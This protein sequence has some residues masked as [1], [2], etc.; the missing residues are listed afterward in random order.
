LKTPPDK[1][2]KKLEHKW[3]TWNLFFE[4]KEK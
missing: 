1:I 3:T 2:N 4:R